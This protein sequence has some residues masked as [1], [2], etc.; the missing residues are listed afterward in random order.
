LIDDVKA[1]Y[2]IDDVLPA[3]WLKTATNCES[4]TTA[5]IFGEGETPYTTYD[6]I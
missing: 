6:D 5:A 1:S 4:R 3:F 2:L